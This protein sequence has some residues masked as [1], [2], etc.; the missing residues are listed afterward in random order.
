M[1]SEYGSKIVLESIFGLSGNKDAEGAGL[2]R[3]GVVVN[4]HDHEGCDVLHYI[5]QPGVETTCNANEIER[6]DAYW[7]ATPSSSN[8][9]EASMPNGLDEDTMTDN[10]TTSS[11]S[12]SP[13]TPVEEE[14]WKSRRLPIRPYD[15]SAT[16]E[17]T[18][19]HRSPHLRE[20]TLRSMMGDFSGYAGFLSAW[21]DYNK[22]EKGEWV[23]E[24][25][26]CG[27]GVQHWWWAVHI[28]DLILVVSFIGALGARGYE[29]F[30]PGVVRGLEDAEPRQGADGSPGEMV[31]EK[32]TVVEVNV[33]PGAR[34]M[35]TT[36]TRKR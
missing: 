35:E 28:I 3:R 20:I 32:K 27:V 10:S 2:G 29:I 31:K 16:G 26:T 11:P 24:F 12:P 15:I 21:F 22:G 33:E 8:D 1:L 18:D 17:C 30:R 6:H 23:V 13:D 5:R 25:S 14:T 36:T 19:I 9:T 4:G 34:S 7:P